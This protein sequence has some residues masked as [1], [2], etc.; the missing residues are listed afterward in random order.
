[1]IKQWQVTQFAIEA[2]RELNSKLT[3]QIVELR[4]EN[5][6]ISELRKKFSEAEAKNIELKAENS[7]HIILRS[8]GHASSANAPTSKSD[9]DTREIRPKGAVLN[10][11]QPLVNTTSIETEN[12]NDIPEQ[13]NLH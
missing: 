2:L 7:N 3:S 9:N 11:H 8:N 12:S 4:K 5:A 10:D 1:Y 13:T 6:E